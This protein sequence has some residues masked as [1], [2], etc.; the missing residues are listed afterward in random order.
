M[1][2]AAEYRAH[3]LECHRLAAHATDA[4]QRAMLLRMAETWENLAKGREEDVARQER[5]AGLEIKGPS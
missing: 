2:K 1:K 3:A 5:V 4:A